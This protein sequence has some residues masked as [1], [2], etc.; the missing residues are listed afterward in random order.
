MMPLLRRVKTWWDPQGIFNP[1]KI[2]DPLPIDTD[3]LFSPCQKRVDPDTGFRWEREG[4]FGSAI[5]QCNGAGVCRKLAES[6]GSMCPS[7]HA[8]LEEKDNTRGRA[9][10]FRQI[11]H[12]GIPDDEA[13]SSTEIKEGLELCLSCRACK[14]EC[15][16]NVDMA[17]MKAELVDGRRRVDGVALIR[18]VFGEAERD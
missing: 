16:A 15:P 1:C 11:F 6:G 9:N 2:L 8:T 18:R 10:L 3:L 4:W 12:S 17:T 5:E 7:Y 13:F 14:S